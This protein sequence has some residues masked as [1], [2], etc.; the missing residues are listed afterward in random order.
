MSRYRREHKT[1]PARLVVHKT[2]PFN[3]AELEG[4]GVAAAAE[5]IATTDFLSV[6]DD[7]TEKPFRYCAYPPLRGTWLE[8]DAATQLL[9]TRGSVD[10][11]ATYPGQY[12]PRPLLFRCDQ[13]EATPR[14]LANETLALT[15]M[16][17]SDTQLDQAAPITL[18]A[19]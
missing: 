2:S 7:A 10:F 1:L 6:D 18:I 4:V 3:A 5:R 9:Y 11:F 16:N 13:V 12:V 14:E 15:K 19:A 17:W 8:H